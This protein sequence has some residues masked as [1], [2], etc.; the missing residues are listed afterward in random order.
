V[1]DRSY[2]LLLSSPVGSSGALCSADGAILNAT[3]AAN[4]CFNCF[5]LIAMHA[6]IRVG[7]LIAFPEVRVR[8]GSDIPLPI[9]Y[10]H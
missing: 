2:P 5:D 10:F 7:S 9:Q 4:N 8:M 6:I 1:S 3:I